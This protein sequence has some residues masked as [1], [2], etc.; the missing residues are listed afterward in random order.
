M[1]VHRYRGGVRSGTLPKR[2]A[3]KD[4]LRRILERP[5]YEHAGEIDDTPRQARAVAS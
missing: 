2:S 5:A 4:C 3:F 1:S